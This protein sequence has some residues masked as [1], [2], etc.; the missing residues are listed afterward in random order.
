MKN[1]I[2]KFKDISNNEM[3]I[4]NLLESFNLGN[5][6]WNN[7]LTACI[8]KLGCGRSVLVDSNNN[9]I[10]GNNVMK[11]AMKAG[12]KN[13]V[14]VE[15]DGNT[16]VVVKRI[17]IKTPSTKQYELSLMDNLISEKNLQWDEEQIKKASSVC[18][19]FEPRDLGYKYS[20]LKNFNIDTFFCEA[21]SFIKKNKKECK[22]D[23]KNLFN[24]IEF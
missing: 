4:F 5:K 14:V 1:E 6:E 22:I 8:E 23:N 12:I 3:R 7:A 21:D 13:V 10:S 24:D 17:D 19:K 18:A 11:C 20:N 2:C 9:V 15:T 16:L